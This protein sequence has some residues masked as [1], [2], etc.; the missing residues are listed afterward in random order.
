MADKK[1]YRYIVVPNDV[2]P[3][4]VIQ[5]KYEADGIVYDMFDSTMEE[6]KEE[7]GYDMYSDTVIPTFNTALSVKD[8]NNIST[9]AYNTMLILLD[10]VE[11]TAAGDLSTMLKQLKEEIYTE[12]PE[13][14][15]EDPRDK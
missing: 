11:N 13:L 2:A 1:T 15:P 4:D 14:L 9:T 8:L 12:C 10:A 3:G 6:C 5:I 7:F